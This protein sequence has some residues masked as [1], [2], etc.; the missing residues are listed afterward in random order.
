[1]DDRDYQLE[2][3]KYRQKWFEVFFSAT[4]SILLAVLA[5][6]IQDTL[7]VREEQL[8]TREQ[9][10]ALKQSLYSDLG[11]KL[12]MI[13]VYLVDVGDYGQYTPPQIVQMKRD[14]DR[15]FFANRFL[16]SAETEEK[17]DDF[18]KA[19]FQT[20]NG[21][22]TPAKIRTGEDQKRA[23]FTQQHLNWDPTWDSYFIG[24]PDDEVSTRYYDV[25]RLMTNDIVSDSI[26]DVPN[27]TQ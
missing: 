13:Y 21:A 23:A 10:V 22:G 5:F 27:Q 14:S 19:A 1:M 3:R 24:Q 16:R 26:R 11:K 18:M 20:Y 15:L 9:I 7:K 25:V 8:K 6:V 12:N 2:L 17:Y 4:T